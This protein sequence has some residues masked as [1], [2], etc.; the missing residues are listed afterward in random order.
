MPTPDFVCPCLID[1]VNA[2]NTIK[3]I[4]YPEAE[5]LPVPAE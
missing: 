5:Q 3:S 1:F 4:H 2:I